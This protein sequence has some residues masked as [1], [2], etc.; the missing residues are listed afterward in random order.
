MD[1]VRKGELLWTM[2]DDLH[3]MI[4]EDLLKEF[5]IE[6][7]TEE[8]TVSW[9]HVWRR[10]KPWLDSVEGLT[11][12]KKRYVIPP[13]SNGNIEPGLPQWNQIHVVGRNAAGAA[14]EPADPA[15]SAA[16]RTAG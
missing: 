16:I 9:T 3:R 11:R 15:A 8:E 12:L 5:K 7:L 2:L 13:L 14:T 6:G 4:L 10:L 1:K